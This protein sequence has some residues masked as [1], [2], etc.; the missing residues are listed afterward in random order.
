MFTIV[1]ETVATDGT[2][3]QWSTIGFKIT[4][5]ESS[6]A[7]VDN[8][9]YTPYTYDMVTYEWGT[10]T[11]DA[12]WKDT[13]NHFDSKE[14]YEVAKFKVKWQSTTALVNGFV[15]TNNGDLDLKDWLDD[16]KVTV[17][18]ISI[19]SIAERI[20]IMWK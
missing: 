4:N 8:P 18:V 9:D 14:S 16:V 2:W 5:V 7:N 19:K 3:D 1:V 11:V 6:A 10:V 17:D 13:T 12:K 15:L 20:K